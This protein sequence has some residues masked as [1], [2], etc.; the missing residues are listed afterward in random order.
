MLRTLTP[1]TLLTLAAAQLPAQLPPEDRQKIEA[2]LPKAAP[3]KPTQ[4]RKLLVINLDIWKGQ[5]RRGHASIPPANLA[6]EL[7]GRATG[8]YEAVFSSDVSVFRP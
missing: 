2:A 5:T 8:A 4:P 6:L 1:I 3:A 7:M